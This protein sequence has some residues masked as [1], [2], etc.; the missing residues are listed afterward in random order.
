MTEKTRCWLAALCFCAAAGCG[1]AVPD[2][3]DAF[4]W[5]VVAVVGVL[6]LTGYLLLR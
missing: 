4:S 1:F 3:A 6:L 5:A 2:R